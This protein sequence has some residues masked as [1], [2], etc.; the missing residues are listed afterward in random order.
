LRRN[1]SGSR[2]AITALSGSRAAVGH[3][4]LRQRQDLFEFRHQARQRRP[5]IFLRELRQYS[6][7]REL[8]LSF[9]EDRHRLE[10]Q[11]FWQSSRIQ[12]YLFGSL[13]GGDDGLPDRR[14]HQ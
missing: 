3:T 5:G 2:A 14:V 8:Q 13:Y 11:Y 10:R 9:A 6:N 12:Q 7:E 4:A 1:L